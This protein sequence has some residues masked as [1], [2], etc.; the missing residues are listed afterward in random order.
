M[1]IAFTQ[2]GW[3]DFE[4]MLEREKK[5]AIKIR[6]LLREITRHPY[7]GSGKPEP[8]KH[9]FAGYWSRRI[10]KQHRLV[11]RIAGEEGGERICFIIQCRYHYG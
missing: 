1:T 5:L 7:G 11:Y 3:E 8:L 6:K 10:D 2:T 4:Y 9:E